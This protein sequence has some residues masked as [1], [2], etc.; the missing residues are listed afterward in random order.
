MGLTTGAR[1]LTAARPSDC[2]CGLDP[3]L[4]PTCAAMSWDSWSGTFTADDRSLAP[5]QVRTRTKPHTTF[6]TPEAFGVVFLLGGGGEV[7]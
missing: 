2:V 4:A 5:Y 6:A 7:C 1:A 3:C